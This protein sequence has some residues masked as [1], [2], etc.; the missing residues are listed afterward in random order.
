MTIQ[1]V[2][3]SYA[4]VGLP[5]GPSRPSDPDVQT[6][7]ALRPSHAQVP[8]TQAGVAL[9]ETVPTDAPQGIDPALWRVLTS[10]ERTFFAGAAALGPLTY[11]P[12]SPNDSIPGT[13]QGGRIDVRI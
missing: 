5:P 2:Q 11:G 8:T 10:E 13:L 1:G 6:P 3:S 4:R 12:G 9:A 7:G